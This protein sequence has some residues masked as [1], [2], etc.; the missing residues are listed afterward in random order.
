MSFSCHIISKI[1]EKWQLLATVTRKHF[2]NVAYVICTFNHSCFFLSWRMSI[3]LFAGTGLKRRQIPRRR[4]CFCIS[5]EC[6][7]FIA[8]LENKL[9]ESI[10]CLSLYYEVLISKEIFCPTKSCIS[11]DTWSRLLNKTR[12]EHFK[13]QPVRHLV[14]FFSIKYFIHATS[15]SFYVWYSILLNFPEQ[16]CGVEVRNRVRLELDLR[17]C[18][19]LAID[20]E[21]DI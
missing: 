4:K 13:A 11:V 3:H 10:K 14:T 9:F 20:R 5:F 12:K 6:L 15:T 1:R 16:A 18:G 2:I 19:A 8:M 7:S 21:L 17:K